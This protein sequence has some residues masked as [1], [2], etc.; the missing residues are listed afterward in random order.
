MEEHPKE[1]EKVGVGV[2]GL[3]GQPSPKK[4]R[5]GDGVGQSSGGKVGAR[6][7]N[8]VKRNDQN[9][10]TQNNEKERQIEEKTLGNEKM[11]E[12]WLSQR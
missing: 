4:V 5:T 7:G 6:S 3:A 10:K 1:T 2:E 9:E 12:K 8:L 11:K